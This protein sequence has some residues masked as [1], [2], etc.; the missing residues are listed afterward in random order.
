MTSGAYRGEPRPLSELCAADLGSRGIV[1]TDELALYRTTGEHFARGGMGNLYRLARLDPATG[2]EEQCIGKVFR[3]E[4]LYQLR[5]DEITRADFERNQRA[6]ERIA[7]LDHPNLLA[8]YV[9][10]AI[11]D[12]HLTV[13]PRVGKP[14][15]SGV[16]D[17]ELAVRDRVA[18]LLD[19]VAGLRGLH[20]AGV[21]HR[22]FTLRNV[23]LSAD[24]RRAMLFDFDLAL[25]FDEVAGQSYRDHYQGRI[26]G[27]PGYSVP[28][29]ILDA[30][31]MQGEFS[32]R[33]D[34]YAVG[35]ALFN[36][37]TD[38]LPC[39][40]TEDMW[41]LYLRIA[42]G[43]VCSGESRIAYP[44]E[45]PRPLRPVIERC[46]ERDPG[47]RYGSVAEV[48][49]ALRDV[50]E[51][52]PARV[53]SQAGFRNTLRYGLEPSD[54]RVRLREVFANRRDPDIAM[55]AIEAADASLA[56]YGYQIQRSLG[57][58][59]GHPIYV[60][61]PIPSLLASG[62]FPDP[63]TYP[64]IVTAVDLGGVPDAEQLVD[65]WAGGFFPILRSVRQG[66]MTSLLRVVHDRAG[67]KLLLFSEYVDGAR[68]GSDLRDVELSLEEALGLSYLVA[69]QVRRLH[70][71]GLAHNN[72]GAAALLLK[73]V[74]D[75]QRVEPAMI[76]LVD[77]SFDPA[78]MAGDVRHLA[79]LALDW[80]RPARVA[81][82]EP[83]VRQRLVGLRGYLQDLVDGK[84]DA[85]PSAED[86]VS[87]L[88]TGIAAI[89]P[90]FS[91]LASYGGDLPAYALLLIQHRL[92]ARLW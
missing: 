56:R 66:M 23:L 7:A 43:V 5:T 59:K 28:P 90:N 84:D 9:T 35:G 76:G 44:A 15:S 89:D 11:A 48:E 77:P 62:E 57:R 63:N 25:C 20:D 74:R 88:G 51:R 18:L 71:R 12:N 21:L 30:Q 64:K 27:S 80:L 31:L 79:A 47:A 32:T 46:L 13:T 67:E 81:A 52:L 45:V 68:F 39:G 82:T 91:I 26:V 3:D 10:A 86:L 75:A 92:Y 65:T 22:D 54:A 53:A 41:G 37:F 83:R 61:A 70:R 2:A 69:R 38:A 60:A 19:A 78:A 40:E 16:T 24:G 49:E 34:V 50:A 55:E 6:M 87:G 14:L 1:F 42:D 85:P 73:G 29:E 58:V 17:V 36:L 4:Y 72:V 8:T 33:L